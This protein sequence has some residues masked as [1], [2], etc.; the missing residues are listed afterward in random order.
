MRSLNVTLA[1]ACAALL[2]GWSLVCGGKEPFAVFPETCATPDGMA[3]DSKGRLVIAAPNFNDTRRPAVLFRMDEPG[4]RPYV[5]TRVPPLEKTGLAAPMG[6]CF[7]PEGELYVCDN[8][9]W[10]GSERGRNEGRLLRLDFK[11]DKLAGCAVVARGMEHPNG[12]KYHDGMLYVTQ[13]SLSGIR[14]PSGKLVSGVYRF[15]PTDRDVVVKNTR[16]DPQLIL[17]VVTRNPFCQYGLDGIV[18]DSRGRLFLGNFGDGVIHRVTF[19]SDG[20]VASITEFARTDFDYS[21]PSSK[22]FLSRATKA[23]MRTTDGMCV[24]AED[25]IYVADFSNNA[26]A[27]VTP[28]GSVSVV[29]Q[30]PDGNGMDGG[31]NQPG[32]PIV[33]RGNLVISNFDAVVSPDKVNTRTDL[34]CTLSFLAIA[35]GHVQGVVNEVLANV[36][37]LRAARPDA[38]PMAFWDF[39]GTILKGDI[40]EG[41]EEN[42]VKKFAGLVEE[43]IKAGLSPVYSG[44]EGWRQYRD[45]DYPRMN[46]IGRWLAWPYN[47][48][49]Y[50]GVE[51]ARLE[52]FCEEKVEGVYRRWYFSSSLAIWRA[53]GEAGVENYVVSASPEVFVRSAAASLGVA[54][55]RVRAIRVE[56]DG[57]RM[58]TRVVHPVPFGEGKVENV[59]QLVLSRP[60]GVAVAGFGNSYS[61]DGA[62]LRYIASQPL[63]GGAKG[64]AMMING[65]SEKPGFEGLFRRVEQ[66]ATGAE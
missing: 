36:A 23:K 16:E 33:W 66:R 59:R 51:A 17:T 61:T 12:V 3:I 30:C 57:G 56:I 45:A 34:P 29:W 43:T 11:D 32:E 15:R 48:Q 47:A 60:G 26:I 46:A 44:D 5:W 9:G 65:G 25:N 21:D 20:G 24:D 19:G 40:S 14:H 2:A 49:I 8:Q 18:F 37:K 13:S 6:I 31:L 1:T 22:D 52:R 50:E 28:D 4:G 42:G 35:E 58:T 63:P 55:S 64:F 38:R 54:P 10:S 62:F 39:D 41:L 27:K 7:G 53:L